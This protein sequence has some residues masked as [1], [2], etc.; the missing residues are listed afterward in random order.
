M[1][2]LFLSI[3]II[4]LLFECN[5][6]GIGSTL[7]YNDTNV[8]YLHD[9]ITNK[10]DDLSISFDSIIPGGCPINIDCLTGG[11]PRLAYFTLKKNNNSVPIIYNSHH[12]D[13]VTDTLDVII[14]ITG[15]LGIIP[16][17]AK[18]AEYCHYNKRTGL[19][20]G[21]SD[22][23]DIN[24]DLSPDTPFCIISSPHKYD[25]CYAKIFVQEK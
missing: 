23:L 16:D 24:I 2:R 25:S 13:N 5:Y 6:F 11:G 4:S 21:S 14:T 10:G 12:Q 1:G 9:I 18:S 3:A 15:I 20:K 7:I 19:R 8:V 17:T 22:T